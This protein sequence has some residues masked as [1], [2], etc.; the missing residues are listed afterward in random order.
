M[1]LLVIVFFLVSS[2]FATSFTSR[3][4]VNI[5]MFGKIGYIDFSIQEDTDNYELKVEAYTTGTVAS[6]TGNR[7]ESFVSSGK[8][9]DGLYIPDTFV[10]TKST[11]EKTKTQTYEF[12][13]KTKQVTL[14]EDKSKIVSSSEF[15][16]VEF[17]IVDVNKVEKTT[18]TKIL[19]NYTNDVLSAYINIKNNCNS[20]SQNCPL[21]AVG[22]KNDENNISVQYLGGTEKLPSN[23]CFAKDTTE[24][25][26]LNV[27]PFDKDDEVVD[28]LIAFDYDGHMK[29]AYLGDIFWVGEV[30]A[31]RVY[32]KVSSIR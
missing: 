20:E 22:A 14:R 29:E 19:D 5:S 18:K 9:I 21:V 31:Q 25:Y 12:N 8:I 10:K 26:N 32:R 3:Y 16:P 7:K 24:Y 23:V 28:I 11:D 15:D 1:K 17:K 30:R 4:N 6:L 13:H 2:L 27:Q